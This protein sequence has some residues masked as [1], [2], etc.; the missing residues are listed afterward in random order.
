MKW[1][2]LL[3]LLTGLCLVIMSCSELSEPEV[4]FEAQ[5]KVTWDLNGER[6]SKSGSWTYCDVEDFSGNFSVYGT[7]TVE[8]EG[9]VISIDDNNAPVSNGQSYSFDTNTKGQIIYVDRNKNRWSSLVGEGTGVV[10][11]SIFNAN[12]FGSVEGKFS[13]SLI[14]KDDGS[15]RVIENGFFSV[16]CF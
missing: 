16:G 7:N 3:L 2:Y 6:F 1:K 8:G 9:I 4:E 14:S 11:I 5:D 12:N 13:G 15:I 10:E